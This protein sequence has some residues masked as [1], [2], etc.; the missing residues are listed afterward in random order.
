MRR[1]EIR[2]FLIDDIEF[3]AQGTTQFNDRKIYIKGAVPGQKLKQ[4]LLK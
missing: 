4:K 3:P 1:N 2:D